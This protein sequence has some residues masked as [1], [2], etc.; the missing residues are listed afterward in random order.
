MLAHPPAKQVWLY[1][2]YSRPGPSP[3]L[4]LARCGVAVSSS[5]PLD[6]SSWFLAAWIP[7][8]MSADVLTL[9]LRLAGLP[10]C[11]VAVIDPG[12]VLL[13]AGAHLAARG[14]HGLATLLDRAVEA[15]TASK[16]VPPSGSI[17]IPPTLPRRETND[18]PDPVA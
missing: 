8:T 7:R 10:V 17:P 12:R 4:A 2:Y 15:L 9:A 5:A 14:L 16:E 1:I 18:G 11:S 3:V 13:I 6:D